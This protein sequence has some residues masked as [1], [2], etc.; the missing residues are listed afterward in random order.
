MRGLPKFCCL[1]LLLALVGC[2]FARGQW[3]EAREGIRE[4]LTPPREIKRG[5]RPEVIINGNDI[6]FDG[7]RLRLGADVQEWIDVLGPNFRERL[8]ILIWDDTGLLVTLHHQR[9]QEVR[10]LGVELN[11]KQLYSE[12]EPEYETYKPGVSNAPA[13]F[14]KGYLE[15]NG[16]AID[17]QSTIRETNRRSNGELSIRCSKGI[18]ICNDDIS[19]GTGAVVPYFEVDSRKEDSIIYGISVSLED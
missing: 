16:L 8:G 11:F 4:A 5:A 3:S 1:V 9:K 14:F 18:N 12:Y 6:T 15:I 7:K 2:D 17:A 10:S 19:V 13:H